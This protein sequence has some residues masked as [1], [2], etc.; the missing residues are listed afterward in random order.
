MEA[1]G[2]AARREGPGLQGTGPECAAAALQVWRSVSSEGSNTQ[3]VNL[4]R[5][6]VNLQSA[7]ERGG[8]GRRGKA[9]GR[10]WGEVAGRETLLSPGLAAVTMRCLPT[11]GESLWK[12]HT[13]APT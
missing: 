5:A 9:G 11:E 3:H 4:N 8:R 7:R 6:K 12:L 2:G 1:R 13:V 10:G